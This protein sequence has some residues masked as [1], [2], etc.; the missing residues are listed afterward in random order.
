MKGDWKM[1]KVGELFKTSSGG[2]PLKSHVDYYEN[3]DIPW[4][5]SGEVNNF[6][7]TES[8][9]FITKKGLDNSSAK[10]FPKDSV[11]V[12]MY[13]ATAGQVGILRF[14]ACSNQAVCAIYP[15]ENFDTKF[16]YYS[17][18][19]KKNELISKAVGNA[20]PNI[21]QLKIKDTEIP[22]IS[23]PEQ[24]R[25]VEK[26]DTAF[27]L[28]E[29]AKTNIEKNIQNAKELFQSKLNAVFSQNGDGWEE[30]SFGNIC[31]FINGRN[32]KEV[33]SQIGEYPIYGSAGNIMGLAIKYLCEEETVIIGR[34]GNIS[35]PIFVDHKFWN[36]DTAFG[37]YP[38]NN[39][40]TN[41]FN[42]YLCKNID[43]ESYNK[44]TTIPSLVKTDLQK[45]VIRFP[46]SIETQ[47]KIVEQLDQLSAQ[48][49]LL[50]KKYK[51]KLTNLEE[52]KKSI[53]EKAFKG[54]LVMEV[55]S[56]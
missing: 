41:K 7:I 24:Q 56:N 43:F 38:K 4:L 32:Q 27:A 9:N 8:K 14:E 31:S 46:K 39:L 30:N 48:T 35:K 26:L 51:Q 23:L 10:M 11:L 36:V 47:Q 3:G 12:A 28:I 1:K 37:I 42:Y 52:L 33:I 20:Q 45:I 2:T 50:Q 13:G 29:T 44:G 34:K 17:F 49:D 5:V 18:L 21:S 55:H 53:L 15:N 40:I 6:N 16:V 19:S 25:I 22:D 54:E